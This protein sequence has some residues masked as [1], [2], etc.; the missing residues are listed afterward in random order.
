[1]APRPTAVVE[2]LHGALNRHDLEALVACFAADYDSA[3]PAHPQRAFRGRDQVR[4]NWA[5]FFEGVPDLR[6]EVLRTAVQGD[7]VWT[8]WHW[9]GTRRDGGPLDVRGVT[10]IGVRDDRIVW[11]RLYM[12]ET[13][14]AGVD[15]DATMQRLTGDVPTEG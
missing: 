15:I 9:W 8:E 6:A 4:K 2:R 13:E 11:G 14:A 7:T 12:E 5:A 3:Q 1:M 10:V